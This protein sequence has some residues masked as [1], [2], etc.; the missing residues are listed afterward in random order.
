MNTAI[1]FDQTALPPFP[2]EL[3]ASVAIDHINRLFY[4]DR[5]KRSTPLLM[6]WLDRAN[7]QCDFSQLYKIEQVEID[8]IAAHHEKGGRMVGG[9]KPEDDMHFQR[10]AL[11]IIAQGAQIGAADIH[12]LVHPSFTEI[13]LRTKGELRV[14]TRHLTREEGH[15]IIRAL[16][17]GLAA[18]K[19][20]THNPKEFQNAQLSG[21]EIS[22][23]GLTSVR[24][25]R[26]P[27]YPEDEDAEFAILRLQYQPSHKRSKGQPLEIPRK[28]AGQLNLD[29]MGLTELQIAS[30]K[31]L[32]RT[33]NGVI[34]FSG[35]TG[36]GK[37]TA[38]YEMLVHIARE[39]PGQRLITIED[40]VEYPMPWAIQM[41]VSN[42]ANEAETGDAFAERLRTGLRMD[43]DNILL[44]ELR[45]S[46][47]AAAAI[48]AALTGHQVWTTIHVNDPFMVIDR[49]EFMDSAKLPRKVTCD[50]KIIRGLVALR[51]IP[52]LCPKC[53]QPLANKLHEM[54]DGLIDALVSYGSI[55]NV[56]VRG[57]G[58]DHCDQDG[59]VSR[60]AVA[61]V[62][63]TDADLMSDFIQHGTGI[64]RRNHRNKSGT[65]KSLVENAVIKALA[66][67]CDPLDI[68]K[69]VDVITPKGVDN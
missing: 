58:C 42:A 5:T 11:E 1:S 19:N 8:E 31:Q 27:R 56:R 25:V 30:L 15:T 44:G 50:H 34:A 37:T 36:S 64:A 54:P 10:K 61:E 45:G 32:A 24:L 65:D 46:D 16:C 3:T 21:K 6:T 2:E 9:K 55:R 41:V 48:N 51:L 59:A 14:L 23:L 28:P 22:H 67:Q 13:Q 60:T 35:P 26:G 43:P 40:P 39:R 62:V 38:L 49:L 33:P 20:T 52:V 66:G 4:V 29:R 63:V 47:S 68:E 12:I 53:S 7:R 69:F 18:V 57:P 17:Q